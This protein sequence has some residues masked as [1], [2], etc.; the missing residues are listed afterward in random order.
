M[1]VAIASF[2][3]TPRALSATPFSSGLVALVYSCLMHYFLHTSTKS[4]AIHSARRSDVA[5]VT[6]EDTPST[7]TSAQRF[8]KAC[9]A[10]DL[11]SRN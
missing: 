11:R 8:V 5:I 2:L 4:P 6:S 3:I 7:R 1:R 10:S 9:L